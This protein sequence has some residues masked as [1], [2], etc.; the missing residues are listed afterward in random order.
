VECVIEVRPGAKPCA[1]EETAQKI[2]NLRRAYK[3]T[4]DGETRIAAIETEG[5]PTEGLARSRRSG[6]YLTSVHS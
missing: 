5:F 2:S 6:K 4:A 3:F 1:E